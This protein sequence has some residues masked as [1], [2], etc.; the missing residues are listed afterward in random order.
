M[1]RSLAIT[2]HVVALVLVIR[3]ALT[4]GNEIETPQIVAPVHAYPGKCLD[5]A[6]VT[7]T[8]TVA[9]IATNIGAVKPRLVH[10]SNACFE[11]AALELMQ[12]WG[13]IVKNADELP[14]VEQQVVIAF[15]RITAPLSRDRKVRPRLRKALKWVHDNL[16]KDQ[17]PEKV[18]K[19]LGKIHR[20][21][22]KGFTAM[23]LASFSLLRA[24]ARVDAGDI[25]GAIADIERAKQTGLIDDLSEQ[26]DPL[27]SELKYRKATPE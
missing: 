26:L 15:D 27:L 8:V 2:A 9:F 12:S 23:E 4:L 20:K 1:F 22:S 10:S 21:Y 19:R 17:E 3:P 18:L 16:S 13:F 7:E 24:T 14:L 6:K 25:S 5:K 11:N